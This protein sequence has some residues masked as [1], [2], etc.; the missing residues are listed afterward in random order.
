MPGFGSSWVGATGLAK[1][2]EDDGA[3]AVKRAMAEA[4]AATLDDVRRE[5]EGAFK[6]NRMAKT[7]RARVFPERGD[8]LDAS[9]W[10]ETRAPKII[11]PSATG[12]VIR[13]RGSNWMAVPARGAGT[14]G[15]RRDANLAF[16]QTINRRGARERITPAGFERLTGMKLRFVYL[17]PS[18]AMLV[19]DQAMY[20]RNSQGNRIRPYSPRGRGSRLYGPSGQ[21]IVVFRLVPHVRMKK[22]LDLDAVASR[23]GDRAAAAIVRN[24]R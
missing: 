2:I 16:G 23:G 1:M 3:S 7:W 22:R 19:V 18:R 14:F 12:A 9:G 15:L 17:G 21:T 11:G 8:S 20:G 24:W 13:A 6:G 5:T 10:I 4:T